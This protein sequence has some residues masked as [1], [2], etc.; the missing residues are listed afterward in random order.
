MEKPT[1]A[2]VTRVPNLISQQSQ[3]TQKPLTSVSANI[4]ANIPVSVPTNIPVSVPANTLANV[5][6]NT[7][8]NVPAHGQVTFQMDQTP[9]NLP[10]LDNSA[11]MTIFGI[12]IKKNYVYLIGILL[13]VAVGYILWKWYKGKGNSKEDDDSENASDVSEDDSSVDPRLKHM[14]N[15][16]IYHSQNMPQ[17]MGRPT[18]IQ[19]PSAFQPESVTH[20]P[21]NMGRPDMSQFIPRPPAFQAETGIHMQ[22]PPT[23]QQGFQ[24][25]TNIQRP[26]A[27]QPETGIHMPQYMNRETGRQEPIKD[28]QDQQ[29]QQYQPTQA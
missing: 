8:A 4:P 17:N 16:P 5:P 10:V 28:E 3:P 11:T 27:F 6:A 1:V 21:P 22:R 23:F 24:N 12:T 26:S 15:P 9:D 14:S 13:L 19:K 2:P 18:D 29:I 25:D 7:L 20:M